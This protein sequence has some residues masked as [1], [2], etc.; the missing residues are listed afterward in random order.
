MSYLCSM[1]YYLYT[2]TRLDKNEIFY[3]GIGTKDEMSK[4]RRS[5]YRRAFAKSSRNNYWYNISKVTE[6]VV[7]IILENDNQDFIKQ[8]EIE[9]IALHKRKLDGGTLCNMTI[10]GEGANGLKGVPKPAYFSFILSKRNLRNKYNLGKSLSQETKDKISKANKGRILNQECRDKISKSKKGIKQPNKIYTKFWIHK[11]ESEKKPILQ[12]DLNM[13][14]IKEWSSLTEASN[15]GYQISKI[16]LCCNNKRNSH[17]NYKWR[18]KY[19]QKNI[20]K[21]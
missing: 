21:R 13:N 15:Q 8:K 20:Q 3:V 5:Q 1:K 19:P 6:F 12:Y 18:F 7:D 2:H 10:G 4:T 11:K 16:S 9:L 17:A 14:F